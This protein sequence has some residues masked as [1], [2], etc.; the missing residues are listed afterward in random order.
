MNIPV[1]ATDERAIEVLAVGLPL[2][3]GAQLAIDITLRSALTTTGE[4]CPGGAT[5]NGAAF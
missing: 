2:H 5:M 1:S 4:P 3:Q